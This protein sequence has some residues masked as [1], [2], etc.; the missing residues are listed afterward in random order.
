[1]STDSPIALACVPGAI[2]LTERPAHFELLSR[3][4]GSDARERG[5]H[6]DGCAFRFDADA[7][8][9][10]SRWID[11]ERRC[12]PFRSFDVRVAAAEGEIRVRLSGPAGV[13]AFLDA[14]LP[15]LRSGPAR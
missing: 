15:A 2:P 7:W 11:N 9:D 10:I 3:L 5:E 8:S 6:P 13:R 1:M 4:S 12:C 14:E